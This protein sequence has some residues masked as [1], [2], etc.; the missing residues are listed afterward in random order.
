M[1]DG[2]VTY[3]NAHVGDEVREGIA[4]CEDCQTYDGIRQSKDEAKSLRTYEWSADKDEII[5]HLKN[6]DDFVGNCHDPDDGNKKTH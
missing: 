6:I 1:T 3:R 5:W 2:M 4:N